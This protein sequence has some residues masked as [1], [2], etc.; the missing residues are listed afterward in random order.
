MSLRT[1][2]LVVGGIAAGS[3]LFWA[4]VGPKPL[5]ARQ[6]AAEAGEYTFRLTRLTRTPYDLQHG[7]ETYLT[8]NM[9]EVGGTKAIRI[10]DPP[11]FPLIATLEYQTV[12]GQ[13]RKVSSS[14]GYRC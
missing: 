14:Y 11:P 5:G 6:T 8:L 2:S 1:R 7:I 12:E 3:L 13:K 4:A 10:G 9:I